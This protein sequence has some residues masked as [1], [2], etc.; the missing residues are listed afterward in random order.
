MTGWRGDGWGRDELRAL[1]F[2]PSSTV[3][4]ELCRAS[5]DVLLTE[6]CC[7]QCRRYLNYSFSQHLL[8]DFLF[9]SLQSQFHWSCFFH[10]ICLFMMVKAQMFFWLPGTTVTGDRPVTTHRRRISRT[11]VL[12]WSTWRCDCEINNHSREIRN[13]LRPLRTDTRARQNWPFFSSLE[14]MFACR[15]CLPVWYFAYIT[16][17]FTTKQSKTIEMLHPEEWKQSKMAHYNFQRLKCL[18]VVCAKMLKASK[19]R[20]SHCGGHNMLYLFC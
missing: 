16:I 14:N 1:M 18:F 5:L 20:H 10:S 9:F 4:K 19:F 7:F 2:A 13:S 12:R 3:C 17:R 15:C 8:N 6:L 11:Q